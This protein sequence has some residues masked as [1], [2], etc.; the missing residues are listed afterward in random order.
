MGFSSKVISQA[1]G[2]LSVCLS[3]D[4]DAPK[5]QPQEMSCKHACITIPH[6]PSDSIWPDIIL[7]GC[8]GVCICV[9]CVCLSDCDCKAGCVLQDYTIYNVLLPL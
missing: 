5:A 8:V 4:D 2:T 1:L 9:F 7:L 3:E 6:P